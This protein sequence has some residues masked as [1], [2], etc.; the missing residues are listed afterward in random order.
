[1][2]GSILTDR[3]APFIS[4]DLTDGT[5]STSSA[6]IRLMFGVPGSGVL[7]TTIATATGSSMTFVD[8]NIPNMSTGYYYIDVTNG[9]ARIITTPIWYTRNDGV[10]RSVLPVKMTTFDARKQN[11]G[12]ELSWK[13]SEEM[14]T[15]EFWIERSTNGR[16]YQKIGTVK[17]SGNSAVV[18]SYRFTDG[19]PSGGDNFYRLRTVDL[20]TKFELSKVLRINFSKPYTITVSPNPASTFI[21]VSITNK[22]ENLILQ[23]VDVNGKILRKQTISSADTKVDVSGL[24]KGFY[25]VKISG[26]TSVMTEKLMIQ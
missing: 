22:T 11:S 10:G 19:K 16:D 25:V 18:N 17:A 12:V 1:M 13:T 8:A 4:V 2:M 15:N 26:A 23:I 7:P 24:S 5:T 14:N 20:D 9:T 3:Y 21:E 6:V